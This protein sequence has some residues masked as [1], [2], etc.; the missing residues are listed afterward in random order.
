MFKL[1]TIAE[2]RERIFAEHAKRN[3][4][5][6]RKEYWATKDRETAMPFVPY[7]VR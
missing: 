3:A 1:E 2:K 5:L 6:Q 7:I 4:T